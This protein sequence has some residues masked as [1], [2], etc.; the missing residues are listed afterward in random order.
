MSAVVLRPM[1]AD[2]ADTVAALHAASWR[3][4]YRGIF[5]DRFLDHEAI[6]E[7]Q[8]AWRERL[9]ANPSGVDWGLIAEDGQGRTVGFAYV[10]PHHDTD[11]GHYID[12]LH[13]APD[14]KGGGLGRRLMQAVAERL[15]T[16][17]VRPLHLWVLDAN[18]PAKRFYAR[19]GA[20]F[21][22][23][24]LDDSLAGEQHLVWRC[25]WRNP[26]TLL[27]HA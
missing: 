13:V 18:E 10:M 25:V 9:Q 5:S 17:P 21:A 3:S 14:F 4:A 24:R 12:N 20:E 7:R 15:P 16:D 27:D 22:E 1:R 19:L 2:D 11:W 6:Q 23:Q 8:Q 26:A